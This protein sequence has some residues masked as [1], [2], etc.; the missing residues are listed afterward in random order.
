MLDLLKAPGFGRRKPILNKGVVISKYSKGNFENLNAD[1]QVEIIHESGK[2]PPVA[3]L[4]K[5]L[6]TRKQ[7]L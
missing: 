7:V 3:D 5:F 2:E 6:Q 4:Q 1:A